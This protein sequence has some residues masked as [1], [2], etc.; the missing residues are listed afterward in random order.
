[1]LALKP[2]WI[3][4]AVH[5]S[6]A[7]GRVLSRHGMTFCHTPSTRGPQVLFIQLMRWRTQVEW[8]AQSGLRRGCQ[9]VKGC[10][11]CGELAPPTQEVGCVVVVWWNVIDVIVCLLVLTRL[12]CGSGIVYGLPVVVKIYWRMGLLE[13][14]DGAVVGVF[15]S[16]K[17]TLPALYSCNSP[18]VDVIEWEWLVIFYLVDVCHV[19]YKVICGP[20]PISLVLHLNWR[21]HFEF[22]FMCA[23]PLGKHFYLVCTHIRLT[24][25]MIVNQIKASLHPTKFTKLL[26]ANSVPSQVSYA[27]LN[28]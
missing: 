25:S 23:S 12:C 16:I 2:A 6:R 19:V 5:C 20:P 14:R 13:E 8:W 27:L 15:W 10:W 7:C 1:M 17:C 21:S 28:K 22:S 18:A 4:G 11:L 9:C 26:S 3:S 24:C